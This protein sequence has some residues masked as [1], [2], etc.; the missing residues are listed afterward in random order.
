M[1]GKKANIKA[2]HFKN[3]VN[4]KVHFDDIELNVTQA[5][6]EGKISSNIKVKV[7]ADNLNNTGEISSAKEVTFDIKETLSSQGAIKGAQVTLNAKNINTRT[8]SAEKLN[9]S[10]QETF[11]NN[12]PIIAGDVEFKGR[13]IC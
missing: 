6:N 13:Q 12:G 4:V 3:H 5:D 9:L 8:L 1:T 11:T 10:A 7:S 2:N